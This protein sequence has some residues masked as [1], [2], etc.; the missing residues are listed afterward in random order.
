MAVVLKPEAAATEWELREFTA[1]RLADF[2]VP[3]RVVL[4]DEIPKGPTGK[5]Q[6]IGLA[7]KL[8]LV[9][10]GKAPQVRT[11]FVPPRTPVEQTLAEIWIQVLGVERV[12]IHDN[13]FELGGDSLLATQVI[14]RVQ[15]AFQVE[16][17]HPSFFE[18]PTVADLAVVIAPGQTERDK[19]AS[20]L[21]DL[22]NLSDEE[23]ERLLAEATQAEGVE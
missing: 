21:A 4:V 16:L 22:E 19:M 12:G 15:E 1:S 7:D 6:R 3:R 20:A 23:A 9:A 10:A 8:G 18:A 5:V 17:T 14:S 13:F 11:D 2:K